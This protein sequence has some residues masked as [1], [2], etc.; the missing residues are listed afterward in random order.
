MGGDVF[1]VVPV[2]SCDDD[3]DAS[4]TPGDRDATSR[5]TSRETSRGEGRGEGAREGVRGRRSR[6]ERASVAIT[7]RG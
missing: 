7:P 6:D 2:G 5:E 1:V 3:D 4:M